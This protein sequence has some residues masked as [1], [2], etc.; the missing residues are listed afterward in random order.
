M[1]IALFTAALS[2]LGFLLLEMRLLISRVQ[3]PLI[4]LVP[5]T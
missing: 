1:T 2:G 4:V 5:D 3:S